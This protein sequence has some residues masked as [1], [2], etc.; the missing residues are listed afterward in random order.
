VSPLST[1]NRSFPCLAELLGN[2]RSGLRQIG[3]SEIQALLVGRQDREFKK[4][5]AQKSRLLQDAI[6]EIQNKS[7]D[8]AYCPDAGYIRFLLWKQI[9]KTIGVSSKDAWNAEKIGQFVVS[10][11]RT[12]DQEKLVCIP[13]FDSVAPWRKEPKLYQLAHGIWLI[14]P[15]GSVDRFLLHLEA[16]LGGVPTETEAEIRK[17]NDPSESELGALL[18][19][20][21][22]VFRTQGIFSETGRGLWHYGLPLIALHNIVAVNRLDSSD[23]LDVLYSMMKTGSTGLDRGIAER[24]GECDR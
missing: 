3:Y 10:E 13:L 11:L 20:P 17:I 7:V 4:K 1:P 21:L 18:W 22:L 16:L 6:T 12:S 24:M 5:A 9:Y 19:D 2:I 23:I 8:L 14:E 15:S